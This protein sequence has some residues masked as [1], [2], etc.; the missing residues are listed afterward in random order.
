MDVCMSSDKQ[1]T[2]EW[3]SQGQTSGWMT[4]RR[5]LGRKFLSGH[6][7]VYTSVIPAQEAEAGGP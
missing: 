6:G 7:M 5:H 4:C 1:G 2:D 3:I